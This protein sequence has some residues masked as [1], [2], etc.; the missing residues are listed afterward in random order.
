M[1]EKY[2]ENLIALLE[3][4]E[5]KSIDELVEEENCEILGEVI[6]IAVKAGAKRIGEERVRKIYEEALNEEESKS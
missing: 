6:A 5:A 2:K 4:L 1:G 3:G